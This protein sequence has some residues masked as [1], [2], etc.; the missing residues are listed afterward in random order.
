MFLLCTYADSDRWLSGIEP[1]LYPTGTTFYRPFSYKQRYFEPDDLAPQLVD[2]KKAKTFVKNKTW[3]E[4]FFGIRFSNPTENEF[5][6]KFI[7]L[8]KINIAKVEEADNFNLYFHLGSFV[9]PIQLGPPPKA[10]LPTLDLS[11]SVCN[12]SITKLFIILRE[13]DKEIASKW[14]LSDG[15][16]ANYWEIFEKS[17]SKAAFT[18]MRNTVLLRLLS[19]K[20]RGNTNNL[21]P[22]TIDKSKQTIGYRL[23]Q[24]S[25]YDLSM[26]Y[27]R[28]IEAG[29]ETP[30]ITHLFTLA[31]P[32]EELQSSRNHIQISGNYRAEEIWISPRIST[33]GPIAVA[34]EPCEISAPDSPVDQMTAKIAGLKVPVTVDSKRWPADRWLNL[35]L[36]VLSAVAAY[37]VFN[38]Y[39]NADDAS[40][41]VILVFMT[42]LISLAIASGKDVVIR[43]P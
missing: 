19:I 2:P 14:A 6:A 32:S 7:P 35:V 11:S 15:F 24:G 39:P 22:D 20:K 33:P 37:F 12:L 41:K 28:L 42:A 21:S 40:Q 3:N 10:A 8:R 38:S 5:L 17:L 29:A 13:Q 1:M 16:P 30:P 43:K 18:K 34:L 26:S 4:G 31:N 25:A 9:A 36:A 27:T 23:R